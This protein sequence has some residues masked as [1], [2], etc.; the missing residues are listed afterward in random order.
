MAKITCPFCFR[1]F[2]KREIGYYCQSGHKNIP[3]LFEKEPIKCKGV[4]EVSKYVECNEIATLRKCPS[5]DVEIPRDVLSTPYFPFS[6]V[7]MA[8]SG[9][10][11][12]I[13]VLIEELTNNY[14][15]RLGIGHQNKDTIKQHN[16][17]R[18]LIYEK[19][20]PPGAT[21]AG[22]KMP[23]IWRVQNLARR[24]GN[25]MPAYTLTI[26]DG[27]GEDH[28]NN[29]NP[30]STVCRYISAS[31]AII[32]TVDPLVLEGVQKSGV[33]DPDVL[34]NSLGGEAKRTMHSR[35][36]INSLVNY[37]KSARGIPANRMLKVPVAVVLTK[38][39]TILD[40]PA[41]G[42][43]AL[44]KTP[45]VSVYNGTIATTEFDQ[46]DQEI[47]HWLTTIGE[48][49]LMTILESHFTDFKFF[50]VSSYGQ[51]PTAV[52]TLARDIRPHRV[53]DPLLW[54]FK[55]ARFID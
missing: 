14:E 39:D 12:Y 16:D 48:A 29:L 55:K 43:G 24:V 26:Y 38:F 27:A 11:N 31:N 36:V 19:H 51:P 6:I 41:F 18:Q 5:C 15:L 30:E 32:L 54:L 45:N 8:N 50:G 33:V 21:A 53:L 46:I 1:E 4:T 28:M 34:R 49:G 47:R 25:R 9:K 37:I 20:Q 42:P 17:N 35:D 3:G 2:N 52:N 40:H 10:T 22:S 44:V 13:T 23:Q 7:G